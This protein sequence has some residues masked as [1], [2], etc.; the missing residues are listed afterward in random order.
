MTRRIF[1]DT[2]WTREPWSAE[3]EFMWLGLADEAGQSWYAISS[4][5]EIDPANNEFISGAF[6]L[7]SPDEPRMTK[8]E[9]AAAVVDFCGDVDE[10]W[11][12]IPP[13]ERFAAWFELGEDAE[14]V[15]AKY[16]DY[17]LQIVQSLV[18]PWPSGWPVRVH[19][20]YTAALKSGV[21]L[22]PR[23]ENHLHPRVHVEWNQELFSRIAR[24]GG[25]DDD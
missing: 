18:K 20:L 9:I 4:E 14:A 24:A 5:A 6:N 17:D 22:P 3:S 19:N 8:S 1:L 7:I 13:L 2:E 15:Y 16:R 25:V 11:V 21:E 12:W 23:A 10:F